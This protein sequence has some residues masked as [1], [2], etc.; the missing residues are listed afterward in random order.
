MVEA[1]PIRTQDLELR[2]EV[3]EEGVQV[4]HG[5]ALTSIKTKQRLVFAKDFSLKEMRHEED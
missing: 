5:L 2:A 4:Q 3:R 1:V